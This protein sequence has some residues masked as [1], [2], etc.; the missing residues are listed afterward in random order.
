MFSSQTRR[1]PPVPTRMQGAGPREV[2]QR[3]YIIETMH[4]YT[5]IAYVRLIW[6][7]PIPADRWHCS[8]WP[9]LTPWVDYHESQET[10]ALLVYPETLNHREDALLYIAYVRLIWAAPI[11]ADRW[12]CS[13]WP[14]LTPWVDY[15]ESQE[16]VALLVYPETLNHRE[17]AL[18]YIAYVMLIWTAP[19]PADRWHCSLRP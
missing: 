18:L 2:G 1:Y 13:L 6:A 5:L 9:W 19:I 3:P 17:D 12:H 14:W 11:P 4:P 8:L 7:A 16:T 15:H 10:V